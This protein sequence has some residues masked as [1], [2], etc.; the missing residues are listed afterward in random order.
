MP[1]RPEPEVIRAL[2]EALGKDDAQAALLITRMIETH[3]EAALAL[4]SKAADPSQ[5]RQK[6]LAY[7]L[8]RRGDDGCPVSDKAIEAIMADKAHIARSSMI[9]EAAFD[10]RRIRFAPVLREIARDR[11]DREWAFAVAS[12]GRLKDR[13]AVD[14]LMDHT[15]GQDTPFVIIA[16]LVRLRCPEGALVFEPNITQPEPQTRTFALWGLAALKYETP[17]GALIHLLDDPD[18]RTPNSFQPGQSWRAAQALSDILGRPYKWGDKPSFDALRSHCRERFSE[19]FIQKCLA[20][21]AKG[22]LTLF[23]HP[24]APMAASN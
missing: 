23:E 17:L 21:L 2:R 8:L 1:S 9:Q 20:A 4:F 7:L 13:E 24:T 3:G 11:G 22:R 18:I 6:A 15:R 14:V 16:A 10:A 19:D 5:K 12:L